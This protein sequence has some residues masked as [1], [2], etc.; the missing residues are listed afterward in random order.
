MAV[1][2]GTRLGELFR[3]RADISSDLHRTERAANRLTLD[4]NSAIR[5]AGQAATDGGR[6]RAEARAKKKGE[7]AERARARAE[8]LRRRFD[9]KEIE[10]ADLIDALWAASKPLLSA[11]TIQQL[12]EHLKA[13]RQHLQR[14]ENWSAPMG[15]TLN[16]IQAALQEQSA[17]IRS[18]QH[19]PGTGDG[20]T[21]DRPDR[22]V[23]GNDGRPAPIVQMG[24]R[25]GSQP[26]AEPRSPQLSPEAVAALPGQ[27][28]VI[29]FASEPRD[30][31]RPDLDMEIR[32]IL[33]KIDQAR[34]GDRIVLRPWPAAQPFDVIPGFSRHKP[35]MVQ[36]SGHG[37]AEGVLMMG[38]HE[39]SEPVTADRLI[40]M[41]TWTGSNLRVVFFNICD[42]EEHARAAAQLVDAAIGMRGKMHD[43]P[44]R[45]FAAHLYSGLA[46]GESLKRAFHQ[47]CAVIG[48]EPD[49]AIPQL[50][51]RHGVDPHKV[52]L[53]RPE[54]GDGH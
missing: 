53:V 8:E 40:Q 52:V 39:R 21:P 38:P 28:T 49:S 7:E 45:V 18:E 46:F 15:P 12:D 44:A 50:F 17:L 27:V 41:F 32:E 5:E 30:L 43:A 24:W 51:F 6:Q 16:S 3:Q 14:I 31:P 35:H 9:G 11:D 29:L 25:R 22:P 1:L 26:V 19:G 10:I 48:D 37:T 54:G 36:F 34:F 47:A 20:R 4:H 13:I 2:D 42:S 23:R 33:A